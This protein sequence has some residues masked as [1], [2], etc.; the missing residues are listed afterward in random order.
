MLKLK[1]VTIEIG[2]KT[3]LSNVNLHLPQGE[4]H[5]LFGPNGCGKTTLLKTIMGLPPGKVTKGEIL[6]EGQ[7]ISTLTIDERARKGIGITYQ[8]PPEI[9]GV[10]FGNF[11]KS[12]G[13]Y[14]IEEE[15]YDHVSSLDLEKFLDRDLNRG[16]SGGELKRSELMQILAQRPNLVMFDE[17]ESG[18]DLEHIK[19]VG[20]VIKEILQKNQP[21]SIP[22]EVSGLIV[23]HTG[24]ILDYVNAEKGYIINN[25]GV[26]CQGNARD[27]FQ[28]IEAEGFDQCELCAKQ[29]SGGIKI[30]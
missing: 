27:I 1:D 3:I 16:F 12:M 18:V 2:N 29:I 11:L 17:P 26:I 5:V 24:Y 30:D 9:Q 28:H 8:H 22:R 15:F 21:L 4:T 10:K 14:S 20:N 19:M 25:A 6:Y 7:D 23:T 13:R